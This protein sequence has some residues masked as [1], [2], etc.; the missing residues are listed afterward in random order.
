M[1]SVFSRQNSVTFA[2]LYFVLQGQTCLL[3]HVSLDCPLLHSSPLW[4]KGYLFLVLVLEDLGGL[5]RTVWLFSF[6]GISGWG[7]D[8]DYCDVEWFALEMNQHPSVVFEIAS[9]Y[10]IL[11]SLVDYDGYSISSKG[12]LP[13]VVDIM[14]S[15][16]NS[17]IPVHFSSLIPKMV[18][19]HSCHLLLDCIQFT[20]IHGPNTPGAYAIL[21]FTASALTFTIRH[22]HSWV[23]FLLW[24]SLFIPSGAISPLFSSSILGT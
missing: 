20:L 16:L 3:L 23:L 1:T 24:L 10:C 17:P 5:H 14:S 4:W 12:S 13:I 18:D 19:V 9:K 6:F 2:L 7:K 11:N 8:L 22:I 15:E 21:F